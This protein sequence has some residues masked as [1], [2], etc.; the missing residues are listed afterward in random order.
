[1]KR[2]KKVIIIAIITIIIAIIICGGIMNYFSRKNNKGSIILSTSAGIP[3][4]WECKLVDKDIATIEHK[5]TKDMEPDVDGGEIQIRYVIKGIKK[6][7][8]KFICN[9]REIGSD[10]AVE[11][12]MYDVIVDKDLNIKIIN[13]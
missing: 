6:G 2:R 8:T 11:T 1:M 7:K 9:Y 5:Y 12:N 13:N 4:E 10:Y 3:Y